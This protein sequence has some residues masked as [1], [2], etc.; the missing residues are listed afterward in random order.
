MRNRCLKSTHN[1]SKATSSI[2]LNH[3]G[4]M[5]LLLLILQIGRKSA[6]YE[7]A[8]SSGIIFHKES[9][10]PLAE[11][12]VNVQFL[13]PFPKNNFT[14]KTAMR[15]YLNKLSAKCRTPSIECPLDFS[16]NF[17]STTTPIQSQLATGHDRGQSR[18]SKTRSSGH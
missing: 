14:M 13:I 16:T 6:F 4:K 7:D 17:N 18:S 1:L 8:L 12:F 9:K 2:A 10:I 11:K 5:L 3:G 15:S